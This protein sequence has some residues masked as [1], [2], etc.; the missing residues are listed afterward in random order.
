MDD[1]PLII[2]RDPSEHGYTNLFARIIEEDGGYKV[3]VK[4]TN[5][6][7]PEQG[8]WGE[9]L[10]E[11]FETASVMIAALATEFSIPQAAITIQ[12]RM[13]RLAAGTRH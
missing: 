5:R 6:G 8:A 13:Q 11:S 3:Q 12:I 1:S 7:A 9:E 4:L 2:E 10:A